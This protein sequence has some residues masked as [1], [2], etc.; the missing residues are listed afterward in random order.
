MTKVM[1]IDGCRAGWF[2][3][4]RQ[5]GEWSFTLASTL[6][7]LLADY[8]GAEPIFI[9]IPIGLADD[10]PRQCDQQARRLL[11]PYRHSSV[12]STP[13]R[14]AVY[15]GDYTAACQINARHTGS[16]ITKQ[17]WNICP[18]IREVD[19]Y[20]RRHKLWQA[21]LYESH[22]EVAFYALN[23][24]NPLPTRKK[25]SEGQEQRLDLLA[26]KIEPA[27]QLFVTAMHAYLRNQ[28]QADDILDAMVLAVM[29]DWT[30]R[31]RNNLVSLPE[32]VERDRYGLPMRIVYHTLQ[33]EI[34]N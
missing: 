4:I 9:D 19:T 14:D 7:V 30:G 10:Q 18:K 12:F 1:G 11:S 34:P 25:S 15:A 24:Q 5:N 22:P 33:Q 21:R 8:A 17:T 26:Q 16:R 6:S 23:G 31:G 3:V 29:A 32:P 20:L 2:A 27:R 13:V 28:L